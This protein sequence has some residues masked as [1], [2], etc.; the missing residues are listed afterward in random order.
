VCNYI[1]AD[2]HADNFIHSVQYYFSLLFGHTDQHNMRPLLQL[3]LMSVS[4]AK[5]AEPIKGLLGLQT[6]VGPR[7]HVLS[8]SAD[9]PNKGA[10]LGITQARE[11]IVDMIRVVRKTA[12][13]AH[14]AIVCRDSRA[15]I[16][17]I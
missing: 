8:G 7:N 17:N 9:P 2:I 10:L 15:F 4:C 12:E 14:V 6:R 16:K 5:T 1:T 3:K 13:V 11:A